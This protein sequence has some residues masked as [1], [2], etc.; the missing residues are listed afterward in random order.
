MTFNPSA[1]VTANVTI[2]LLAVVDKRLGELKDEFK[3]EALAKLEDKFDEMAPKIVEAVVVS[4]GH[5]MGDLIPGHVDDQVINGVI[6]K[7]NDLLGN[8]FPRR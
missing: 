6:G 2:P 7:V 1:W 5:G 4:I 3:A 8:L